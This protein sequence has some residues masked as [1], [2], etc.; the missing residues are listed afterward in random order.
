MQKDFLGIYIHVPFC[1][2]KCPY[3]DFYSVPCS[4]NL[5]ENYVKSVCKEL[6]KYSLQ[7]DK[8]V[9]TIYFGG[10]TPSLLST[11][12]ISKILETIQTKFTVSDPEITMEVNPADCNKKYFEEVK[13][14]GVNRIS[15]GVQS[16]DDSQLKIL[17]RRHTVK[18]SIL[19]VENIKSAGINNI[20]LDF[21]IGVPE[22]NFKII[23]NFFEFCEHNS[24]PHISVYLLKIEKG[25]PY[26]YNENNFIFPTD[27]QSADMY[28]YVC[29]KSNKIGYNHYEISNFSH[30][31][32]ESRHNMKYWNLDEYLGVG[33][34]AHSLF[35][36]A[37]FY[38]ERNLSEFINCPK[39]GKEGTFEPEIEYIMLALR[40]KNGIICKNFEEKFQK[41][42]P[43]KYF[44]RAE[45][46]LSS[47]L[48][49]KTDDGFRLTE[50]G[51][52]LSNFVIAEI[53]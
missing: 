35:Q 24:I 2:S 23:D 19:A 34:G 48:I 7:T 45:K 1:K 11:K 14:M 30:K 40:T 42:M 51:F 22:Q 21:I 12:H 4:E 39:A 52:L 53:I 31:N 36:N 17:G 49:E 15:L 13:N 3:C 43:Q 29:K 6:S 47:G 25:T 18:D 26:F 8:M 33:P 46:F 37:R 38:Y 50:K 9:D 16:F 41:N 32:F 10:G 27:D 28:E 20:S 44:E 5:M